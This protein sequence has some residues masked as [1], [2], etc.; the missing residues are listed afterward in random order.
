M[1]E[2]TLTPKDEAFAL[3]LTMKLDALRRLA[4]MVK[5]D[6]EQARKL[7]DKLGLQFIE[8]VGA[9]IADR[10]ANDIQRAACAIILDLL[11]PGWRKLK[12]ALAGCAISRNNILL[13]N[14][15]EEVL[16]RDGRKCV[17]CGATQDLHAHHIIPWAAEPLLRISLDN[18]VTL[19]QPCHVRVH[20]G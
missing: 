9:R 8:A 6:T 17:S 14:W 7:L 16:A 13:R 2:K 12:P 4:D 5:H 1:T 11:T 20:H 15:R 10:N 18:G 19:C 3:G